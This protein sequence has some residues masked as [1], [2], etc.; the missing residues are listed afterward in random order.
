MED[1]DQPC[2]VHCERA[3]R[4]YEAE[5]FA[6]AAREFQAAIAET[7]E[8][9]QCHNCLAYA[10]I[11][12]GRF[13]E[14]IEPLRRCIEHSD[15]DNLWAYAQLAQALW[16]T[17]K[18]RDCRHIYLEIA[19]LCSEALRQNVDDEDRAY[20]TTHYALAEWQLGHKERGVRILKESIAAGHRDL[21]QYMT[22][23]GMQIRT[24][25]IRQGVDTAHL[26]RNLPEYDPAD[27]LKH[28]CQGVVAI[29]TVV[30]I[31]IAFAAWNHRQRY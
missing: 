23:S 17:T 26:A 22:L 7:P 28:A 18:P 6:D 9:D 5:S 30:G 24:G 25:Q 31:G 8:C 12:T 1:D 4:F 14:S 11:K 3:G 15:V 29:L 10:L 20:L 27:D 21:N 13:S 2:N 19:D 16:K